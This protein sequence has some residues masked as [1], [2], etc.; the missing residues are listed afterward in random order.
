VNNPTPNINN[1]IIKEDKTRLYFI[2]RN[3]PAV[4]SVLLWTSA[5]TGVG[6][7]IALGNHLLN[8][9]CALLV[10]LVTTRIKNRAGKTRVEEKIKTPLKNR[11]ATNQ[12][13]Q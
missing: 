1:I 8:G 3:N 6:A 12:N 5:L 4:T 9:N 11:D 13:K 10:K 7:A 2:K